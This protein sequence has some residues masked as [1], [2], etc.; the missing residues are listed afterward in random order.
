MKNYIQF[1]L[2]VLIL[3]LTAFLN[4]NLL[5]KSKIAP[6]VCDPKKGCCNGNSPKEERTEPAEKEN[7]NGKSG[8]QEK[9]TDAKDAQNLEEI[10][11]KLN[12]KTTG[13]KSLV[14][15]I[16]YLY[17]QEPELLDS[18]TLRKGK[19][20]YKK[21]DKESMIRINFETIQQD[22]WPS[23]DQKEQYIFNDYKITKIDYK[24]KQIDVHHLKR[25][26]KPFDA[27]E[28]I[29]QNFPMVGFTST[30]KLKKEFDIQKIDSNEQKQIKLRLNVKKGSVY[31]QEYRIID[32][33][34]DKELF[35]P[36]RFVSTTNQGD[37]YDIKFD[38]VKTNKNLQNSVFR[39]EK[40]SGFSE[41][42]R[43]SK[44]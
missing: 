13:L 42:I 32:F 21:H 37:I 29:S 7:D 14:A 16:T 44:D 18:R 1:N 2:T 30:E 9:D 27:F 4:V 31:A 19:I 15:E 24:L 38:N 39:L 22:D 17:I 10:L 6:S 12:K 20:F 26:E 25:S 34:V 36:T 5:A 11:E 33:W 41:N 28:F 3:I 40:P 23:E 43:K 35:L 8:C